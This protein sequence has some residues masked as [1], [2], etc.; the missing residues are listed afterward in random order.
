MPDEHVASQRSS[1]EAVRALGPKHVVRTSGRFFDRIIAREG[2]PTSLVGAG[3]QIG[4]YRLAKEPDLM[5][6]FEDGSLHCP[7][8]ADTPADNFASTSS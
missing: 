5:G 1:G 4:I 8:E 7:V 6:R 3:L 2:H